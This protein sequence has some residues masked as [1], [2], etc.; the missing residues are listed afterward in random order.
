MIYSDEL[1][2]NESDERLLIKKDNT[3]TEIEKQKQNNTRSENRNY[4]NQWI[5]SP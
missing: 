1:K 2:L 3:D 4:K 5:L